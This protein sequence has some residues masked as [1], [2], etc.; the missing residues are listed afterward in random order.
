MII[1]NGVEI[2][3]QADLRGA[4]LREADLRGA[5]LRRAN[6]SGA[7]LRRA[8]LSGA[9]LSWADLRGA[10]LRE[11]DLR[12]ANLRRANLSGANLSW[13]NLSG[14]NL[15][16]ADLSWANLRG[17]TGE[18]CFGSFGVHTAIAAGG[19][20]SIGCERHEYNH[21]LQNYRAIGEKYKYSSAQIDFYYRWIVMAIEWLTR[22][23]RNPQ[24]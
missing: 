16:W 8:N 6:L 20:I 23:E 17:A 24:H 4:N 2:K 7:N 22:D 13:A 18:F 3:P 1:I 12:G 9:N 19:Y 21:W 14:A 11:A 10:N 15:S 5:N